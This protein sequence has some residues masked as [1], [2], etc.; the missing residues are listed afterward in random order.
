MSDIKEYLGFKI[1]DADW[2][3]LEEGWFRPRANIMSIVGELQ[4]FREV[5]FFGTDVD[6]DKMLSYFKTEIPESEFKGWC[7]FILTAQN[8]WTKRD[9]LFFDVVF[10]SEDLSSIMSS[11]FKITKRNSFD[12]TRKHNRSIK[13]KNRKTGLPRGGEELVF[14]K[15]FKEDVDTFI[16]YIE[17]AVSS[18]V[19]VA[20]YSK[21]KEL[22]AQEL[23]ELKLF[24]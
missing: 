14:E 18:H 20:V 7:G 1:K 9:Q 11:A 23:L 4:T 15:V 22:T 17:K 5:F 13:L 19:D 21:M 3:Q 12:K 10:K 24:N 6:F 16:S 8:N 2:I